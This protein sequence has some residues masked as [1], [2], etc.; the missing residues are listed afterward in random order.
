M[1]KDQALLAAGEALQLLIDHHCGGLCGCG[2]HDCPP[3]DEVME[4]VNRAMAAIE[5][6]LLK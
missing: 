2:D 6:A 4:R 3:H 5:V 1:T